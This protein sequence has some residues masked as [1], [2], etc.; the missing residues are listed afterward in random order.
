VEGQI[1]GKT[2]KSIDPEIKIRKN[3]FLKDERHM[4]K[5]WT[6]PKYTKINGKGL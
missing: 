2:F 4:D 5:N 6:V 1:V 3:S